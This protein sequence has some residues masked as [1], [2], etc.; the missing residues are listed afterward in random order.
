[1]INLPINPTIIFLGR[2]YW[3]KK[4]LEGET[5]R[6]CL[7]P[8]KKIFWGTWGRTQNSKKTGKAKC[9]CYAI[10]NKSWE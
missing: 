8:T 7:V 3:K 5:E 4:L 1:M 10:A 6:F 2:M 9:S